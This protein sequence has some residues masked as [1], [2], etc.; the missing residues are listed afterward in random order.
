MC[1]GSR[2]TLQGKGHMQCSSLEKDKLCSDP[3][4]VI[5]L[6]TT[7][8]TT[9]WIWVLV[10]P[11]FAGSVWV[12]V[13]VFEEEFFN[14]GVSITG[15]NIFFRPPFFFFFWCVFYGCRIMLC[16]MILC[17]YRGNILQSADSSLDRDQAKFMVQSSL[18][19]PR[20]YHT[21]FLSVCLL[22]IC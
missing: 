4:G 12:S 2:C 16:Q 3:I 18:F 7:H 17:V 10:F 6:L 15:K 1:K 21:M 14:L 9:L 20:R 13:S 8:I 22:A 11:H 19:V 5:P